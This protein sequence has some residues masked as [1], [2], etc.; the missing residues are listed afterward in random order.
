MQDLTAKLCLGTV[1]FGMQYG[2][3]NALRRQPT[4]EEVCAVLDIAL[5]Q[6]IHMF[7]TASA[8]GTAE[9]IL[10]CYGLVK[11]K[12]HIVSKLSPGAADC[13][14]VVLAELRCSLQRLGAEK[15]FCY[16][17][18]RA[19]D[20]D[21][22]GIMDGMCTAK[23]RGLTEKI[24]I[25]VYEPQEAMQAAQDDRIDAI[26]I[27]YNVLDQRLDVCCFFELAKK[28]GKLIFARSTFLQGLLLME[29]RAAEAKVKGS[30]EL[31]ECFQ[32]MAEESDCAPAEAA[33]LYAL[34][35]PHIDYV[36]F[37]VDTPDQLIEN[38]RIS[39]KEIASMQCYQHLRGTFINIS[40][41][42]I[43]PNLW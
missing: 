23:E 31:I 21:R 6:G 29:P 40:P 7:D 43:Q 13:K 28:N 8:Y 4:G 5:A 38:I 25:S 14:E 18:H 36:V 15:L 22:S 19:E 27:P 11:K 3:N 10:G 41:N 9:T 37:G 30:G 1:Q 20:L 32:K 17:L 34:S 39:K 26:Q 33:L 16:M 24:G 42:I 35:H 12:A 2:I